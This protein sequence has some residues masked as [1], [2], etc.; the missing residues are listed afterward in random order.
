[1]GGSAE[2]LQDNGKA[3]LLYKKFLRILA[4][5]LMEFFEKKK[6]VKL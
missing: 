3:N 1:M 4:G 6:T 2:A 5:F